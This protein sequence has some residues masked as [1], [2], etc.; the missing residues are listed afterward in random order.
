MAPPRAQSGDG[1]D[2]SSH[3]VLIPF[4]EPRRLVKLLV[5]ETIGIRNRAL[6]ASA[7]A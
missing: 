7:S 4:V 1:L 3:G 5:G 2:A 6:K